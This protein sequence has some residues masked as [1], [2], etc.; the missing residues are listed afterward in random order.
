MEESNGSL[1]A[2]KGKASGGNGPNGKSHLNGHINGH[3]VV[4]RR[5]RPAQG[6]GLISRGF[7]IVAR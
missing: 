4:P 6:R 2:P 5:T 3:A 1:K 7:S